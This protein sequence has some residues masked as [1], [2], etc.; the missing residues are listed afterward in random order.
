MVDM[1]ARAT[2][3][4]PAGHALRFGGHQNAA[5]TATDQPCVSWHSDSYQPNRLGDHRIRPARQG[6][7]LARQASSGACQLPAVPDTDNGR[8]GM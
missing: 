3:S 6:R 5:P 2:A 1:A 8:A 4:Q 7:Q